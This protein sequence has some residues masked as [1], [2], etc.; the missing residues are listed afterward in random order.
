MGGQFSFANMD[1]IAQWQHWEQIAE[2]MIPLI[3]KL[4]RQK[5]IVTV[6]YDHKLVH[7]SSIEIIKA[8]RAVNRNFRVSL[9]IETAFHILSALDETAYSNYPF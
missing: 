9:D 3:G 4:Y 6:V 5:S 7:I 8:F 2:S 1:G